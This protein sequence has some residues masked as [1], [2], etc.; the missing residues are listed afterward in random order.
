MK[1]PNFKR[2]RF[3]YLTPEGSEQYLIFLKKHVLDTNPVMW[4]VVQK[5][6]INTGD[7]QMFKLLLADDIENPEFDVLAFCMVNNQPIM[8]WQDGVFTIAISGGSS[9]LWLQGR[10]PCE[11]IQLTEMPNWNSGPLRVVIHPIFNVIEED[12][13]I[14][15]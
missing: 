5:E 3:N 10:N 4:S 14:L 11:E 8:V 13:R 1:G 9:C 7:G 2:R 15:D 6:E 12:E